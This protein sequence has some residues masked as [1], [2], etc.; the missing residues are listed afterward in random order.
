MNSEYH[1]TLF[2]VGSS[3]PIEFDLC[4]ENVKESN[5]I[6]LGSNYYSI[7]SKDSEDLSLINELI[8]AAIKNKTINSI[9]DLSKQISLLSSV[10]SVKVNNVHHVA[11]TTLT[12]SAPTSDWSKQKKTL[13]QSVGELFWEKRVVGDPENTHEGFLGFLRFNTQF[14]P[15]I[16]NKDDK[17]INNFL[18]AIKLKDREGFLNLFESLPLGIVGMVNYGERLK[19]FPEPPK[20]DPTKKNFT[21]SDLTQL[22]QYMKEIGFSGV[23]C[24]SD[25]SGVTH[26][27]SSSNI[28]KA[29]TP[30]AMHSI[31]KM[32]TGML[33][34]KMIELGII[35]KDDLD[36]PIQLDTAVMEKLAKEKR[37]IYD[38]LTKEDA[39][40]LRQ[41]MLHQGGLSDYL[42][43]YEKAIQDALE[44]NEPT[45]KIAS[46][47]DFIKYADTEIHELQKGETHYSNVGLL[48][49][50]LA[51]QHHYNKKN[52]KDQKSYQEILDQFV[53]QPAGLSSFSRIRPEGGCFNSL[54]P[55][56][57][58][59]EGGPAGGYWI[60]APDLLKFSEWTS[61]QCK[62]DDFLKLVEQY[63]GEFSPQPGELSHGGQIDSATSF[64]GTF[65]PNGIHVSIL[66][67]RPFQAAIIE[68][69]IKDHI[70]ASK[71]K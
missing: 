13:K 42:P 4:K 21:E 44:K 41:L 62:D 64:V 67:N 46:P 29:D 5:Q 35:E 49:V 23:V 24:L 30:F 10:K 54:H 63:G 19:G 7:R 58:N 71:E 3:R 16:D 47:E 55:A 6:Q 53:L 12:G 65:L 27:F 43:M 32:F 33:A 57:S 60:S 8:N 50:G 26:T 15:L 9:E 37:E 69:A 68:G 36:K 1:L 20:L 56:A 28:L 39:P 25:S 11:I 31:G 52:P 51:I 48:L 61:E 38:H 2:S 17:L 70:L 59:I 66:S 22:Q 34:I 45:P 18:T 40:T 14:D